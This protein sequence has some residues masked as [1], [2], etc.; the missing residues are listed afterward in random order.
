MP[1][2]GRGVGLTDGGEVHW[3][4]MEILC[5]LKRLGVEAASFEPVYL[6]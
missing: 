2:E 1:L 6:S 5:I 3:K 4:F